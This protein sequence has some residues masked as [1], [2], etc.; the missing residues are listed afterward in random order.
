MGLFNALKLEKR[1]K[2]FRWHDW[3]WKRRQLKL[4][5]KYDPL[6][7]ASQATG[8]VLKK[9]EI[10]AKQ[11]HSALR[12]CVRVQLIKNGKQV[13]AFLPGMNAA[14][15]VDEHD[16][17]LIE[18]IGGG[19]GRARGDLPCVRYKV[20]KVNGQPLKLLVKGKIEKA[21]R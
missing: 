3:D 8:I 10:S 7:G 12:R 4:K 2:R 14:K 20:I 13:T 15:Y 9:I 19:M 21:R 18:A 16:E 17:V 6:E 1:R 11:P 5:E